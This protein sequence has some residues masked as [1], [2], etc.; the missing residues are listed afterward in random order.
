VDWEIGEVA[1][2]ERNCIQIRIGEKWNFGR[3]PKR[4]VKTT[5]VRDLERDRCSQTRTARGKDIPAGLRILNS[6]LRRRK[7]R[8]ETWK[9]VAAKGTRDASPGRVRARQSREE[10]GLGRVA[11]AGGSSS[12]KSFSG[13]WVNDGG[14]KGALWVLG[15]SQRKW[16]FQA[17]R[18]V[19]QK[20]KKI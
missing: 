20:V 2:E 12:G 4:G 9:G 14:E 10:R 17:G 16:L 8:G 6:K 5:G 18:Y 15:G 13:G 7:I 3:P 11:S 19:N 1:D